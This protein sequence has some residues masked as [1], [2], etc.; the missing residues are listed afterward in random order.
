MVIEERTETF[1]TTKL[2]G[3]T[4]EDHTYPYQNTWN[5][6]ELEVFYIRS[7]TE[8]IKILLISMRKRIETIHWMKLV[9]LFFTRI[10]HVKLVKKKKKGDKL[11]VNDFEL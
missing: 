7:R 5:K 2:W 9:T 10:I 8:N 4:D 1:Q 3:E 11:S 6:K